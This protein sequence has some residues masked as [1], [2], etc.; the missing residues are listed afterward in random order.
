[1]NSV[2]NGS[3]IGNAGEYNHV[4]VYDGCIYNGFGATMK[5]DDSAVCANTSFGSGG[6]IYNQDLL[7]IQ[8]NSIVGHQGSGNSATYHG[9]GIFNENPMRIK[10]RIFR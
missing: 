1:M 8:N 10:L 3:T 5:L 9:G 7:T 2:Q 6:G 4:S